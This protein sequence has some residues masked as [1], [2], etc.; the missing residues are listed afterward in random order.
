IADIPP[1]LQQG[2]K[3]IRIEDILKS[4]AAKSASAASVTFPEGEV[5]EGEEED[6]RKKGGG[7]KKKRPGSIAGREQRHADRAKRAQERL[8]RGGDAK[9]L[10]VDDAETRATKRL[11]RV[12]KLHPITQPRKGKVPI[13]LPITVRSL[14][15]A[16]GIKAADLIK[17]L[18]MQGV[19]ATINA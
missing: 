6:D 8:A 10:L 19:M 13:A 7:D 2:N 18:M 1:E 4:T 9:G 3:P 12:R 11:H 16:I 5:A 15:E 14:S 17:K